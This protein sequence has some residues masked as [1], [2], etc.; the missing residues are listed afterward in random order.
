MTDLLGLLLSYV[1]LY[2]YV[3]LALAV[4]LSAVLLP[5]PIN[6]I[7]LATGAFVSQGYFNFTEVLIVTVTANVF[8]DVCEFLLARRYGNAMLKRSRLDTSRNFLRVERYIKTHAGKTV[9]VTRFVGVLG[10]A[11]NLLA[12]LAGVS[13]LK[14]FVFDFLGNAIEIG[15]LLSLGYIVGG[16]WHDFSDI[17]EVVGWILF[18]ATLLAG[19]VAV[20]LRKGDANTTRV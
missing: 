11:A 13:L 10:I 8:G 14:F 17:V 7:L 9:F 4:L 15:G 2:K 12:G 1:L 5:I 20:F 19:L 6:T 3:A 18:V 16:Y